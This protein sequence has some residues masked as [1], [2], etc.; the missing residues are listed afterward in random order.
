MPTAGGL[1]VFRERAATLQVL[2]GH[3]GGPYWARRDEG[4][5]TIPKGELHEGEEPLAGAMREF[6][7]ELG[8]APPEGAVLELGEIRQRGG[9]RVIAFA[10]EG[11]FYPAQLLAGTFEL[12]WPP[13]SGRRQRFP[14]LDRVAWFDLATAKSKIVP[15]QRPLL[16][17]LADAR[18]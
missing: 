14:E 6:V 3:M 18:R 8:H 13:G 17:R 1:V 10:V 5:W 12:E 2:L 15:G 7:E 11:E 16:D 9:K 4:A